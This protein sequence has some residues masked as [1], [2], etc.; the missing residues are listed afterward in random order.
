MAELNE[1]KFSI[2]TKIDLYRLL[3]ELNRTYQE[4]H[5][6]EQDCSAKLSSRE[7]IGMRN[8]VEKICYIKALLK[9]SLE[10]FIP[11]PIG[12]KDGQNG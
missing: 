1:I 5:H 6:F 2:N 7:P 11:L 8:V 4:L 3:D 10:N 12:E 9:I